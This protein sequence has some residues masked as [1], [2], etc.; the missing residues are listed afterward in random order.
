MSAKDRKPLV[1]DE[2]GRD[3]WER[4]SREAAGQFDMFE[5][6]A[7]MPRRSAPALARELG[8]SI[9]YVTQCAWAGRW[10]DRAE[11]RD[12]ARAEERAARLSKARDDMVDQHLALS[13]RMLAK[14][15][16]AIQALRPEDMKPTEIA[17]MV[18]VATKIQRTALDM[19]DTTVAVTGRAGGPVALSVVPKSESERL[20]RLGEISAELARRAGRGDV[21]P[22]AF[23]AYLGDP[24][25]V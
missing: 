11:K 3:P 6:Y 21:D 25:A 20:A 16:Q 23:D 2:D 24:A 4:Q 8:K 17:R 9:A 7:D 14:A 19:P 1:F 22:A 10:R 13:R 18:E 5:R 12:T 15:A